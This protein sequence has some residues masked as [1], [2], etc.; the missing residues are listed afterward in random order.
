MLIAEKIAQ[1]VGIVRE[2]NVDCWL[3]FT[4]ETAL[5]GDPTLPF[6]VPGAL[7]W[8]SALIVTRDGKTIAIV[9][10]Y[11]K[12]S[13]EDVG[14]WT[15]VIDYVEGITRPLQEVLKRLA[16]K[17][18]AV[19]YSEDSEVCDGLTH[20]MYLTLVRILAEIGFEGRL[21]PAEEVISALRQRKTPYELAAMRE[22]IA[23]TEEIFAKVAPFI[24]PGRTEAE[25]AGFMREEVR[26]LGLTFA[27]DPT[28][29]PAVFTG[30]DTAAAHYNP[31][32]RVIARGHVLNMDFGVK[33]REYCSDLQRTFYVLREGE[34]EAP[35]EVRRGFETI[36][37]SI[38]AARSLMKPGVQGVAVDAACRKV[39][40][41]AGYEEFP[42]GLGHQVGRFAHDGTALLGPAWEKYAKKP[43]VPLEAGM[44]F[45]LEPR[46]TVPGFGVVTI[47]NMVVVGPSGA[48]Y[49]STPQEA[50]LLVGR[51]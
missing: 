44:V 12:K 34:Q 8:H 10:R 47:E 19:N 2:L 35:S 50:L 46:L 27:W 13:I 20:G 28:S 33:V 37:R 22:A 30:P 39:I 17:R 11:D 15:E 7:T 40:T 41:D 29:C 51:T 26:K 16:P 4:R 5:N 25:V 48:E 6:L 18:I 9:G 21:V 38:E 43:F 24:A 45:T 32:E 31:T 23:V 3:T 1:A 42:H 14:A 36:V 49:L